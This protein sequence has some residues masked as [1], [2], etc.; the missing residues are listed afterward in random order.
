MKVHSDDLRNKQLFRVPISVP[1]SLLNEQ[2]AEYNHGQSLD[3]LNYR[4]GLGVEEILANINKKRIPERNTTQD[5]VDELN[6][7]LSK[8]LP[9]EP[10][11]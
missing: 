5:D 1:M 11:R 8:I 4:G 9:H 3:K 10:T 7:I 2:M 6:L